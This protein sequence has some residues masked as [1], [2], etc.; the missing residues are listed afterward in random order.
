MYKERRRLRGLALPI[1]CDA[2]VNWGYVTLL[3]LFQLMRVP[4]IV[5]LN[6]VNHVNISRI[7]QDNTNTYHTL[8]TCTIRGMH[9]RVHFGPLEALARPFIGPI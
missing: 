2:S 4:E 3:W 7:N 5:W 6:L 8:N 9:A 1:S